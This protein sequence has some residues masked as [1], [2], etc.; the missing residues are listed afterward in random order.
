MIT[1]EGMEMLEEELIDAKD[2][3]SIDS[4]VAQT[5]LKKEVGDVVAVKT[6]ATELTWRMYKNRGS[7]S[8]STAMPENC[9]YTF[10]NTS[11]DCLTLS[12]L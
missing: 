2:V 6:N 12:K 10:A 4:P 9:I 3:I 8:Q 11:G 5:L 1:S 7:I